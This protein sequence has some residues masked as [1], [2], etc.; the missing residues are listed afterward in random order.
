M[1]ESSVEGHYPTSHLR[2]NHHYPTYSRNGS[3]RKMREARRLEH[4]ENTL[5]HRNKKLA[6]GSLGSSSPRSHTYS[7]IAATSQRSDPVY[8]EIEREQ[9]HSQVSDISDEEARQISDTSRQSSKSYGDHRPL[10]P[11][12]P[13]TDQNF[14]AALDAAYR[15]QL[16]E[17]NAK[18]VSV[19]DGQTVVCHLQQS[20]PRLYHRA[21]GP[22]FHHY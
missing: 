3:T 21:E 2:L 17:H 8:E 15:Q 12:N 7:E 20:D 22:E 16:M 4:L 18:T 11:Y 10:I 13:V 1:P 6:A 14:H 5:Q 9:E 19:L